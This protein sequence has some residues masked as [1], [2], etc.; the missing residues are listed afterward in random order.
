[1]KTFILFL[2]L[3]MAASTEAQMKRT[4]SAKTFKVIIIDTNKTV[5]DGYLLNVT[6]SNL[7]MLRLPVSFDTAIYSDKGD[8]YA[9]QTISTIT[10]RRKGAVG[11]GILWGSVGGAV[12]G[13]VIGAI[14]YKK[15]ACNPNELFC[16]DFGPSL[17]IAAGGILGALGGTIIGAV[18]GASAKKTF[19]IGG[20][21]SDFK[22]FQINVLDRAYGSERIR[23][24]SN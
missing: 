2:A 9:F 17:D 6:D 21:R 16:L 19:I 11:R 14:A 7:A 10:V 22:K 3:I 15:P 13:T 18:I 4:A 8:H 12:L 1:M 23:T 20:K 5:H 24:I